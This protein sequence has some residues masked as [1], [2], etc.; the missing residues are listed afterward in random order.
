MSHVVEVKTVFKDL[1]ALETAAGRLGLEMRRGQTKYRWYGR[2]MGDYPVPEGFTPDQLGK[3]DHA[4]HITG[5]KSA[6]EVGIVGKADGSFGLLFD[7]WSGGYGLEA[8]IGKDAGLLCEEYAIEVAQ[9]AAQSQGWYCERQGAELVI[10]ANGGELR[11]SKSNI[12]AF[13]FAGG[14][15]AL[16]SNVIATAMGIKTGETVKAEMNQ[17]VQESAVL[18]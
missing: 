11:V 9:R 18:E 2:H 8:A 12:D 3:C 17:T 1:D 5:N 13:G 10:Y 16:A 14:A 4:L 15:C 7:F 6:Y